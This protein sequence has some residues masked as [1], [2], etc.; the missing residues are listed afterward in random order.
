MGH[1]V[2]ADWI[3]QLSSALVDTMLTCRGSGRDVGV[4]TATPV[5]T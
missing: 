5:L 1:R 2:K 4:A 3:Q